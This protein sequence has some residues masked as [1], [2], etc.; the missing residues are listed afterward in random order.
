MSQPQVFSDPAGVS[1]WP[2]KTPEHIHTDILDDGEDGGD[3]D[4]KDNDGDNEEEDGDGDDD[5][6][7]NDDDKQ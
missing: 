2:L 3:D 6:D 7:D 5:D 1:L 4:D